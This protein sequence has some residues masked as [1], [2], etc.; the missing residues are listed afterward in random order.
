MR[1][2]CRSELERTIAPVQ[3]GPGPPSEVFRYDCKR[4]KPLYSG[5][6]VSM[7]QGSEILTRH[8][9]TTEVHPLACIKSRK[10]LFEIIKLWGF[11]GS[12][13]PPTTSHLLLLIFINPQRLVPRAGP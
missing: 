9:K 10:C 6:Q 5:C 3:V 7:R 2:H 1:T 4:I 8:W 13:G 12:L 11:L